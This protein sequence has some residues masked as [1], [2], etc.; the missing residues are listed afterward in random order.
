MTK[1]K[2]NN[3]AFIVKKFYIKTFY[4]TIPYATLISS[5]KIN[6]SLTY[7]YLLRNKDK[8]HSLFCK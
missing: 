7:D 5:I 6:C 8:Q 4:Y 1:N 2:Q 3:I